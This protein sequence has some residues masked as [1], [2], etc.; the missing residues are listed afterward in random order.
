[1]VYKDRL[2]A[3]V[4]VKDS[5]QWLA[6]LSNIWPHSNF[7]LVFTVFASIV[8]ILADSFYGILVAERRTILTVKCF[9]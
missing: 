2:R 8:K 5:G 3:V 6:I 7:L 4:N 9:V 1:M